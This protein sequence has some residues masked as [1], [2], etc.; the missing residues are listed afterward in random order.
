MRKKVP[1]CI[2]L[3]VLI[4]LSILVPAR[5]DEKKPNS[6][7]VLMMFHAYD[8]HNCIRVM[9]EVL[10]IIEKEFE[11]KITMQYY[12]VNDVESYKLLLGLEENY[13]VSTNNM[14]PVFFFKGG[15]VNGEGDV[16]ENL[17]RLIREKG[18]AVESDKPVVS[19]VDLVQRFKTITPLALIVV[20]LL[21]GVNPCAVTVIVFFISFLAVQG[22]RKKEIAVIGLLFIAAVYFT[23]VMIG[24]GLLGFLYKMQS[25]YM[26]TKVIN[27][28]VGTISILFS[29]YALY[30]FIQYKRTK[31]TDNMLL[32]LPKFIKKQIQ[33]IIGI[34]L[35]VPGWAR[36][37]GA[38]KNMMGLAVSA[39][40]TGFLVSALESV[41]VAKI[42]LPTII[43]V[44]KTSSLKLMALWYLLL[45]NLLFI[46]PLLVIFGFGL[47][48]TTSEKF[49]SV[50]KGNLGTIK[51][52][53]TVM[54]LGLGIFLIWRA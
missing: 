39:L 24:L 45:Y 3:T 32:S 26:V 37:V 4:V 28:T 20:G 48:G 13:R 14:L 29:M 11:G 23:Y 19:K 49:Q 41:C 27:I 12:D 51:I 2:I 17:R 52:L 22:Y 30:D 46:V 44:L 31:S 43:F 21:D 8:C 6:P 10:P 9:N 25:F 15:F 50:L 7:P 42:Y 38:R 33:K 1:F 18:I 35:R 16:E 47:A 40:I 54:F 34:E 36:Q 53:M 5:A